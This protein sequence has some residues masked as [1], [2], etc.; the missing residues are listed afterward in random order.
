MTTPIWSTPSG[1]LGTYP[2]LFYMQYNLVAS[3]SNVV[4][5]LISGDLPYGL[6]LRSDGKIY[7][8]P[9]LDDSTISPYN[10]TSTFVVR[11]TEPILGTVRD[12]TF[13]LTVT[14]SVQPNF[15][16]S[17]LLATVYDSTWQEI[18]IEYNN[19]IITNPVTISLLQGILPPGIEIN[20]YGLLRG[21]PKPPINTV[22]LPPVET[23]AIATKA[24][25]NYVTVLSTYN[26]YPN[27][28]ILFSGNPIGNLD[29]T[30]IYYVK[31][32]I[33][34]TQLQI[35][36]VPN[37]SVFSLTN[38]SG[39]MTV[40]LPIVEVNQP[41]KRMYSFTLK[42]SSP[43]GDDITSC[44]IQVTNHYLPASQGGHNPSY[45]INTRVPT[46]YNT[47]PPTYH[48][49]IDPNY[50]FY[51]LPSDSEV[52]V[53]GMTYEPSEVAYIGQFLSDE[54]LAF[55]IMGHDFDDNTLIY[56]FTGLPSFLT[57]NIET[58]WIYG[59]PSI[60]PN[61][62]EEYFFTV[63]VKK[64]INPTITSATFNYSFRIANNITGTI[65]WITDSDLGSIYNATNCYKNVVATC[66]AS[67]VY[68][69]A[70]GALP[71]NLS[72]NSN[73]NIEG[74]ASYQPTDSYTDQDQNNTFTFTIRAYNEDMPTV[75]TSE[76]TFTLTVNQYFDHPTDNLYIKCTPG[77]V[78]RKIIKTLL[79][80]DTLIPKDY[81]YR[82]S[83]SNFG[84]AT[85]IIYA[86][87]YGIES[88]T[89]N[90]YIAAVEKN[91][92]WRNIT[93]GELKTAVAKNEA[94]EIIYEVVYSN[95]I[96]N[97]LK[98]DKNYEYDYRYSTSI[99]E[100]IYWPRLIPIVID[101]YYDSATNV[102]TSYIFDDEVQLLTNFTTYDILTSSEIPINTQQEEAE[103][104]TS[105]TE[106]YARVLYP[107]SLENMSK[108]VAQELGANYDYNLL[109]L[110][111]NSQQLD[112]NTLGFT[113]AWVI[114]YTKPPILLNYFADRS[115]ALDNTLEL[116]SVENL[117]INGKVVFL[118][119]TFGGIVSGVQYYVKSIDAVNNRIQVSTKQ[120]GSVLEL[121]NDTGLMK[122]TF[123]I[124]Y[125]EIVKN[126]IETNWPYTLNEINFKIDRFTVDKQLTYNYGPEIDNNIWTR[127]PS[128]TP[129]PDPTDSEN[130]YVLFPRKTILPNTSQYY[131][132]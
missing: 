124:S 99:S 85:S 54:Y 51:I 67:L 91:H 69:I 74:V 102:Y 76:R 57:G 48:I 107:N 132:I 7:G 14:G 10:K 36:E 61:T 29:T 103:F 109:P 30:T 64:A 71:P 20:E 68:E 11:V 114:C 41:T 116:S 87:A 17:G 129:A 98:Y 9:Q 4:Y 72:L 75:I 88:S 32:V 101:P 50:D 47:R 90:Q 126:N 121:T 122:G 31:A 23:I 43:L 113:P 78:D 5:S 105:L 21:Y 115:Y 92:Y 130:F 94:G 125:A 106:E 73:G 45:A 24:G 13:S 127:L 63:K 27:R 108:R 6:S 100:K 55:E 35:T 26:M 49:D 65:T 96:D 39:E 19:P 104:F 1:S 58:G 22:T 86:H 95:V 112:G 81:L 110:W 70:D 77:L 59:F 8:T 89:V 34:S 53:P 93:L 82:P 28:P 117:Q 25:T 33:N 79:T 97:L 18:A 15:T 52:S 83:D 16:T 60:L 46:I 84:K 131:D 123:S 40:F 3:P 2:A 38:G 119:N 111:M 44:S 37:G 128:A 80:D 120:Q 42:L 118:G 56:E 62:I 66:D 12:R